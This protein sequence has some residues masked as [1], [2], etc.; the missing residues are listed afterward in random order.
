MSA[1]E[2]LS[3]LAGGGASV[4][5]EE[6]E[7]IEDVPAPIK[8]NAEVVSSKRSPEASRDIVAQKTPTEQHQPENL[9]SPK[10][11]A[12][13]VPQESPKK[14]KKSTAKA[15]DKTVPVPGRKRKAS[16]TDAVTES[17]TTGTGKPRKRAVKEKANGETAPVPEPVR[18]AYDPKRVSPASSVLRPLTQDELAYIRNPRNIR[19]PL[20]T[21]RP[22]KFGSER[23]IV[24]DLYASDERSR[25]ASET[26]EKGEK[27]IERGG[28][29]RGGVA[30]RVRQ[31]SADALD[32]TGGAQRDRSDDSRGEG[33]RDEDRAK[34]PVMGTFGKGREVA[35]HCEPLSPLCINASHL[36]L[37]ITSEAIK[38]S[39]IGKSPLSSVCVH[40]TTG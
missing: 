24:R 13:A 10:S 14:R 18:K 19:N 23:E 35:E 27:V 31:D 4:R 2:A 9:V 12:T 28:D 11:T 39:I 7:R 17:P 21:G 15:E 36:P 6:E 1:A 29:P 34:R 30:R 5:Q 32:R 3:A 37:Q 38:A 22:T 25:R 40:A 26:E 8:G 33:R 20:K 16:A